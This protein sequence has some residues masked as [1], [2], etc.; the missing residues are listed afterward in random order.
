MVA[1]HGSVLMEWKTYLLKC[2]PA[3]NDNV[4]APFK[5][6]DI[7]WLKQKFIPNLVVNYTTT[8]HLYIKFYVCD[9][10]VIKIE[11]VIFQKKIVLEFSI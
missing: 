6:R 7:W 3:M 4:A 5:T 10:K 1:A 8:G 2:K 11:N 9:G